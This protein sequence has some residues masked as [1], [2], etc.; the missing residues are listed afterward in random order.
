MFDLIPHPSVTL[1]ANGP[2]SSTAFI[3]GLLLF[4]MVLR[5]MLVLCDSNNRSIFG[6]QIGIVNRIVEV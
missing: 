3:T 1:S 2:T 4:V 6:W 5:L